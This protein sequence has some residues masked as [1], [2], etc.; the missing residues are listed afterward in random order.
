KVEE[1]KD[2]RRPRRIDGRNSGEDRIAV[3]NRS[4][5]SC[6]QLNAARSSRGG[7]KIF[8][9]R[10]RCSACSTLAALWRAAGDEFRSSEIRRD[11]FLLTGLTLD[12]Y[13][14][15]S[16]PLSHY[17][18]RATGRGEL[19]NLSAYETYIETTKKHS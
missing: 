6:A 13:A 4:V 14:T 17:R 10:Y 19:R 2:G 11:P 9:S 5:A 12:L 18:L 7:C 3:A 16:L 8:C 15:A 1:P